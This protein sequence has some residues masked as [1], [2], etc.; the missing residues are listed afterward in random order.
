[1]NYIIIGAD[2]KEYGPV[3]PTELGDWIAQRRA[4]GNTKVREEGAADWKKL[5]EIPE[6]A[7]ALSQGVVTPPVMAT[8]DVGH[9]VDR[10]TLEILLAQRPP[11]ILIGSCIGRAWAL[12]KEHMGLVVGATFV[13][14]GVMLGIGLVSN[15]PIIGGLIQMVLQGPLMGGFYWFYLKLIRTGKAEVKDLFAGFGPSFVPLMLVSIVSSLITLACAVAVGLPMMW[16]VLGDVLKNLD[17]PERL[18][19]DAFGPTV[20]A[21]GVLIVVILMALTLLWMFSLPLVM[22]KKLAFWNAMEISR[23]TVAKTWFG[24]LVLILVSGILSSL[25]VLACCVGVLF[26]A[27]I[28]PAALM[29]AYE[30]IYG[31]QASGSEG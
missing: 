18:Q 6:F 25:G 10:A 5:S 3:S 24:F 15:I 20:I 12:V 9:P 22:D 21:G 8:E 16:P 11:R 28:A 29:Y 2:Q 14:M 4:D 23:K 17:H 13:F 7:A 19:F 27:P 31:S 26:T 1:M 30:D